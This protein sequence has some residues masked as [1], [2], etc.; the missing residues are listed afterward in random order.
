MNFK[1]GAHRDDTDISLCMDKNKYPL[2]NNSNTA[3]MI[4]KAE[5]EDFRGQNKAWIGCTEGKKKWYNHSS[6]FRLE[7]H[8]C[9]T[10]PVSYVWK[11]IN[12]CNKN[13]GIRW[14]VLRRFK[15]CSSKGSFL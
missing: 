10:K 3:S 1:P 12:R 14:S 8:R 4:Y 11:F 13:P 5:V 15:S 6:S 2:D 9:C 7:S